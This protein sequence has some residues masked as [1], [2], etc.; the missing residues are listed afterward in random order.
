MAVL[1]PSDLAAVFEEARLAFPKR[2]LRSLGPLSLMVLL[3][4]LLVMGLA[5]VWPQLD[6]TPTMKVPPDRYP[7]EAVEALERSSTSGKLAVFFNWGEYAIYH[8][9]PRYR[10]SVDGR[11]E[12]VYPNEIVEA[13]WDFTWGIKGGERLLEEYPADFALY[14]RDTGAAKWLSSSLEWELVYE[15]AVAVLYRFTP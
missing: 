14:P 5:V 13:N 3:Q 2:L 15:D 8:L 11:Y 12:T 10:V 9:Y 6:F 1:L 7:V 4:L